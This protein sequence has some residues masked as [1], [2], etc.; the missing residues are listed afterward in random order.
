MHTVFWLANLKGREALV[1][2]E[3]NIKVDLK[4]VGSD[5]ADWI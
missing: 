3:D 2:W 4:E 5:S 1:R